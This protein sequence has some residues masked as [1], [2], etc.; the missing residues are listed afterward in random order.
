MMNSR[1]RSDVTQKNSQVTLLQWVLFGAFIV[2]LYLMTLYWDARQEQIFRVPPDL[3][4]GA[5]MRAND[6]AP[7]TVFGFA[8]Y[9]F[10]QLHNWPE[11]GELDFGKRIFSLQAFLTPAFRSVLMEEAKMKSNNGE[12][13]LRVRKVQEI[14]GH[15]FTENRVL[16]ES[17]NSWVVWIGLEISETI[18]GKPVKAVFVQYPL[19]VVRYD[20]DPELNPWGLAITGY[21]AE[22]IKLT[23]EDIIKPFKRTL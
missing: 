14:V 19:R 20:V 12:L 4:Q 8:Y 1:Y 17:D 2:I 10:Q 13:R 9:I 15:S 18:H 16:I 22:P 7:P 6:V 3:R 23:D 11:N 21:A 5:L